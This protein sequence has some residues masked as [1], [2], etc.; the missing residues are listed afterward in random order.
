MK[1]QEFTTFE[2]PADPSKITG[3][4]FLVADHA[5]PNVRKEWLEVQLS[6]DQPTVLNGALLRSE[7]LSQ[8]R[9][10]LDQLASDYEHLGHAFQRS[11]PDP[12]EKA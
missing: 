8:G 10:I 5:D 7:A 9:D 11:F 4:R 2:N 1:L 12:S 3:V 6:V